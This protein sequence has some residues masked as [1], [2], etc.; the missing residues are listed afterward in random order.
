MKRNHILKEGGERGKE[1][2]GGRDYLQF[3]I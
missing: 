2:E 1:K 3:R